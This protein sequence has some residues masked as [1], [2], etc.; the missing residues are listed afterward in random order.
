[1]PSPNQVEITVVVNGEPVTVQ[2]N[3]HEQVQ[4]LIEIAFSKS[5]NAGQPLANWELRDSA[6]NVLDSTHKLAEYSIASGAT[7]FLSLK[8][9]VGG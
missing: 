9:G 5:N 2:V 3:P 4:A 8:A 6:G 7:L 1:M